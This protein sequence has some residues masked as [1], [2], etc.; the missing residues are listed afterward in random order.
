MKYPPEVIAA[1]RAA[2]AATHV[3]ASVSLAQWALESG[4]GAHCP[5]GNPFGLKVRA[6]ANDPCRTVLTTEWNGRVYVKVMQSF[7]TFPNLEAA[8]EAHAELLAKAPV[9]R[10]AMAALPNVGLFIDRMAARYATAPDYSGKIKALIAHDG[11]AAYD[12]QAA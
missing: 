9:Y 5:G 10:L 11:L 1:A 7:R 12:K 2:M 4:Y 8:F 6:G 3:P